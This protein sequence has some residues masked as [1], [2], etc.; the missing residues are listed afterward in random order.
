MCIV[1][2]CVK[3]KANNKDKCANNKDKCVLSRGV[4]RQ[5][6]RI[7]AKSKKEVDPTGKSTR[8]IVYKNVLNW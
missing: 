5:T 6:T 2:T 8:N 1:K 4:S 7:L 3:G